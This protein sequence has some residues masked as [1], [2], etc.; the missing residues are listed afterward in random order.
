MC[1]SD[2]KNI[3][4][5]ARATACRSNSASR[6]ELLAWAGAWSKAGGVTRSISS[7]SAI[8]DIPSPPTIREE[9]RMLA[10][11]LR[12][13]AVICLAIMFAAVKVAGQRGFH[14]I[15]RASRRERVCQYV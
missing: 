11:G 10:I 5:L 13:L 3:R 2:L 6:S 9:R 15:G 12:L 14:E 4:R 8:A 7:R 1:I